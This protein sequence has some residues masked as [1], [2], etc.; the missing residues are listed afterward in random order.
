MKNNNNHPGAV[1]VVGPA[2]VRG[3]IMKVWIARDRDESLNICT[4]KP[5]LSVNKKYWL[6]ASVGHYIQMHCHDPLGKDITFENSP[7]E[8][9]LVRKS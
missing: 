6:V 1:F 4:H 5:Q 2:E 8:I 7:K 3:E 9:E